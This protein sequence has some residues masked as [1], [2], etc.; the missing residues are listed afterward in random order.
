MAPGR[1]AGPAAEPLEGAEVSFGERTHLGIAA[2][3]G[4]AGTF[5]GTATSSPTSEPQATLEVTPL[6]PTLSSPEP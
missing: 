1:G 2:E 5:D 6:E 4:V 3:D